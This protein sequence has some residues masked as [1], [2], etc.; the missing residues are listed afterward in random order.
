ML[1]GFLLLLESTTG[2]NL[3]VKFPLLIIAPSSSPP[4]S[5]DLLSSV[6][7]GDS[8]DTDEGS[9]VLVVDVTSPIGSNVVTIGDLQE[10]VPFSVSIIFPL[11]RDEGLL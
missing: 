3:S 10:D 6:A 9:G 11:F 8:D 4:K 1:S 7:A 2:A 5:D